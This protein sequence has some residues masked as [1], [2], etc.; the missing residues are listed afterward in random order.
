MAT[1]VHILHIVQYILV[2]LCNSSHSEIYSTTMNIVSMDWDVCICASVALW[3][4]CVGESS[5]LN[6]HACGLKMAISWLT[7][8]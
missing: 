5:V 7:M 3:E 1:I 4:S 8:G 6:W 2:I